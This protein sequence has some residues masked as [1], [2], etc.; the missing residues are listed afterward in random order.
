MYIKSSYEN[1][2]YAKDKLFLNKSDEKE[3]KK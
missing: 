1:Y 2:K 3:S